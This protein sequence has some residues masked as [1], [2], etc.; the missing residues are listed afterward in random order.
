MQNN[1]NDKQ[2]MQMDYDGS[3]IHDRFA[4]TYFRDKY[5]FTGNIISFRGKMDVS[6][7]LIDKE[8]LLNKD[9][10]YSDDAINF[11]WEIPNVDAFGGVA[12]Q[13]YFATYVGNILGIILQ[14]KITVDGDD[15]LVQSEDGKYKKAS[16]SISTCKNGAVL[17]HLGINI[18]AGSKA[19]SF[20]YST[21]LTEEQIN[22]FVLQVEDIFY[23]STRSMFVAT[24]KT[25]V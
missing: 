4:Y 7:N 25:V 14:I 18:V 5:N 23:Q 17:G 1:T 20:A 22:N 6:D 3:L 15:I 21:H 24:T 11:C 9:Y 2:V 12:F 10:I 19:P 16:V 13:R 8:D